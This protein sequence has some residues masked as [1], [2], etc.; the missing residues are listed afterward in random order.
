MPSYQARNSRHALL[1]E[2]LKSPTTVRPNMCLLTSVQLAYWMYVGACAARHVTVA[3]ISRRKAV[4][5]AIPSLGTWVP[6]RQAGTGGCR[7]H[8]LSARY[9]G[10]RVDRCLVGLRQPSE[11]ADGPCGWGPVLCWRKQKQGAMPCMKLENDGDATGR[12]THCIQPGLPST[13]SKFCLGNRSTPWPKG[14]N[15][16]H[17]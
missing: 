11:Q 17:F 8:G 9:L 4:A 1:C 13:T 16:M 3:W 7:V 15:S 10:S 12:Q 5:E 6:S 14:N 2:A